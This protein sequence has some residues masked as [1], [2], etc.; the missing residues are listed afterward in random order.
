MAVKRST[1]KSKTKAAKAYEEAMVAEGAPVALDLLGFGS[2]IGDVVR[3]KSR[4]TAAKRR[5]KKRMKTKAPA[6]TKARVKKK[7][8]ARKSRRR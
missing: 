8:A 6:K 2:M 7:R 1:K 5:A 4:K 3:G